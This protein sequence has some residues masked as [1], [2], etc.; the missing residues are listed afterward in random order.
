MSWWNDVLTANINI[1][2][3]VGGGC[4]SRYPAARGEV[5]RSANLCD[6]IIP[7]FRSLESFYNHFRA[8]YYTEMKSVQWGLNNHTII[9]RMLS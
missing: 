4:V 1:T 7:S 5:G 9:L 2:L 6:P 8:A 3:R